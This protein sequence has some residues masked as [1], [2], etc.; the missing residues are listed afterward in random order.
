MEFIGSVITIAAGLWLGQI[1]I[2][3]WKN[4]RR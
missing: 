4:D 3:W 2:D 1:I